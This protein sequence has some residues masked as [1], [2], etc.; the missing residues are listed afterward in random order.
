MKVL[1]INKS[2]GIWSTGKIASNIG[3]KLIE[4]GHESYIGFG[5]DFAI[6]E[7]TNIRIGTKA[8]NYIHAFYSILFDKQGFGSKRATKA[9][10]KK[11]EEINPDIIHLHN[12]HGYYL[13]LEVLF[14]YLQQANKP[15]VWTLHDCW[16]FTGHCVHFDYIGCDRWKRGCGDCPQKSYPPSIIDDSEKNFIKKKQLFTGIKNMII[17]TPSRWL[18]N[19]VKQSFLGKYPVKVINNGID[20][21]IFKPIESNFREKNNL[22]DK[23]II[24][25]VASSWSRRKGFDYFIELSKKIK[26]DEIIVMVGLT[27]KQKD[28]LPENI[29]GITRTND[30]KELVEIYSAADVFVN[31]TLEDNFPTTNLEAL[32]CGTPVITFNTGGSVESIDD[33]CGVVVEKGD[34]DELIK[35]INIIKRNTPDKDYCINK[36]KK[37]DKN[38]RFNEYIELYINYHTYANEG[39]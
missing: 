35:A 26:A 11:V 15:V 19:L 16:A 20:L 13:N 3:E 14:K 33:S 9:F 8:D 6:N 25:G 7:S 24:L 38:D 18:G 39:E 28:Q 32:A 12:L 34:I 21:S 17:V 23:F 36:A 5:R 10:V 30:I 2:S 29:I 31:P 37:F 27:K 4:L 22:K 1:Q